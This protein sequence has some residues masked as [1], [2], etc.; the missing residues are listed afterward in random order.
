MSDNQDVRTFH[1]RFHVP[2][3]STP[4]ALETS[5]SGFRVKFMREE[6]DEYEQA[7]RDND[8]EKQFD[9]LIDLVYV[10]HGTALMHGFPWSEGW[11]RVQAAN[12]AKISA[13]DAGITGRHPLDVVKPAGW[14][15]AVLMD[16]VTPG[17]FKPEKAKPRVIIL[18]GPDGTGKSTLA[19]QLATL[20]GFRSEHLIAPVDEEPIDTC[21]RY[22]DEVRTTNTGIVF[23]RFHLSEY[24]YGPI[25]RGVN[26]M[27][28]TG[29][30]LERELWLTT[31]P[32]VVMCLPPYEV[33][34]ENWAK[35]NAARGEM[36]KSASMY[37]AVYHAF[38]NIRTTLPT[39][40]YDYT[41]ESAVDVQFRLEALSA[42]A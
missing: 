13:K 21:Y 28:F 2:C 1:E 3:R 27:E 31:R 5:E 33:A 16:L 35:R 26:T 9:A 40:Q 12:M 20:T 18:E 19:A 30:V 11:R 34:Q 10:A 37:D 39:I 4:Q 36:I 6:L 22:L 38:E 23:D 7:I 41:R 15:P 25:A 17:M 24:V 8:L 42:T 32:V 14:S 29:K